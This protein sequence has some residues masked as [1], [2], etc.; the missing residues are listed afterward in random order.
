VVSI[1][2]ASGV[3]VVALNVGAG[4]NPDPEKQ[5]RFERGVANLCRLA[6]RLGAKIVTVACGAIAEG[7]DRAQGLA[8]IAACYARLAKTAKD[9]FGVTLSV[10][11]PHKKS[12][13]ES[14]DQIRSYWAAMPADLNCTLDVA[15]VTFAGCPV[16]EVIELVGKRVAQVHLRDA[17]PGNSLMDYGKGQVDFPAV[18]RMLDAAGYTGRFSM[19]YVGGDTPEETVAKL[20]AGKAYLGQ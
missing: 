5:Q 12:I 14:M 18:F 6:A 20:V 10:E 4:Y 11:A 8:K 3:Q 1:V 16:A 9:E 17:I 2:E 15:H 13:S 7:E 19:E